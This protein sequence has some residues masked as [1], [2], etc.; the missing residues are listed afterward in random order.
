MTCESALL[1]L[2]LPSRRKYSIALTGIEAVFSSDGLQVASED[3]VYDF[4]LKTFIQGCDRS[5]F[6]KAETQYRQR[7]LAAEEATATHIALWSGHT[8]TVRS[9][10]YSQAFHLGGQGFFLS[11]HCNMDQQSS[12]HCFGLFLGMQERGS[13]TFAVDYEFAARS[14]PTEDFVSKY[15]GNYISPEERLLAI[16]TYLGFPGRHSWRMIIYFIDDILHLRAELTIRQ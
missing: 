16:E 1:Y 7:A 2:D 8:S 14:K 4:V 11:A 6:F 5:S 15:K 9:R 12:F 10:V 3:A 13:V